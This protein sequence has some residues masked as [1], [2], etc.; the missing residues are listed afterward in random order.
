MTNG[1]HNPHG[2]TLMLLGATGLVGGEALRLALADARVA[3]VVAPT[4]HALPAHPKLQN[5]VVDFQALPTQA[6][7][8]TVDAVICALGTTMAKAGSQQAFRRVDY[9][10]PLETA[11]LCRERGAAAYALNSALGADTNSSVFYSRVKGE[12][13]DALKALGYPSLTLVRPGLLGG[14]RKE[15]RPR[16]RLFIRIGMLVGPLLPRRWR[17]SQPDA[18]A[19]H[20][21]EGALA[22]APGVQVVQAEA[23]AA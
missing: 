17:V 18:V 8:W 5:P 10:M 3:R 12:L 20:L 4:R 7:W 14:Q 2:K 19:R 16:E 21:L 23:F 1:H 6:A 13:E 9:D 15:D 22:G 11:R